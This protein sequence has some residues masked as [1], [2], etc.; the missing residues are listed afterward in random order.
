MGTNHRHRADVP[1]FVWL[2]ESGSSQIRVHV[3]T[4]Y[5]MWQG[6][7][8][9][10]SGTGL[11][12]LVV[13]LRCLDTLGFLQPLQVRRRTGASFRVS[14]WTHD[15]ACTRRGW[16]SRCCDHRLQE[17]ATLPLSPLALDAPFSR[18]SCRRGDWTLPHHPRCNRVS[19]YI[20]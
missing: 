18:R 3:L 13:K 14:R 17:Q 8:E 1:T 20:V 7:W 11:A 10:C 16:M 9:A 6:E 5:R 4:Y 15:N 2:W 19:T 12:E